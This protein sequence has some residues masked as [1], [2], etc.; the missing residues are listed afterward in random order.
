MRV[1]VCFWHFGPEACVAV[2]GGAS[3]RVCTDGRLLLRDRTAPLTVLDETTAC[4]EASEGVAELAEIALPATVLASA[5]PDS[6]AR[7][8]CGK[9]SKLAAPSLRLPLRTVVA[10]TTFVA[11][12][13][14]G[15]MVWVA[16]DN[17][18]GALGLGRGTQSA[19]SLTRLEAGHVSR[20]A[21]WASSDLEAEPEEA[22]RT[23]VALPRVASLACGSDHLALLDVHGWLWTCGSGLRGAT[24]HGT[25]EDVFVPRRLDSLGPLVPVRRVARPREGVGASA[26]PPPV[27]SRIDKD[28]TALGDPSKVA[29]G[30]AEATEAAPGPLHAASDIPSSGSRLPRH[31]TLLRGGTASVAC[32][33]AHTIV[34][35]ADGSLASWGCNSHGQLGLPRPERRLVASRAVDASRAG[36]IAR[37]LGGDA[38]GVELIPTVAAALPSVV[39]PEPVTRRQLP[40]SVAWEPAELAAGQG[41][42]S[43]VRAGSRH[44]VVELEGG[45]LLWFG[46]GCDARAPNGWQRRAAR[47]PALSA[48]GE[49]A[50][51]R[52]EAEA[53][54][55]LD[56]PARL[57][58]SIS[59]LLSPLGMRLRS[60]CR[61][62]CGSYVTAV[63]VLASIG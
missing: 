36:S 40:V 13:D 58:D 33:A 9:W 1:L 11:A 51:W 56:Q 17:C 61:V 37:S 31:H 55:V 35:M 28:A 10:G 59:A 60:V 14:E 18:S 50:V 12:L 57:D 48:A 63:E 52:F 2:L 16:G 30:K 26:L 21:P 54:M 45:G 6:L 8:A 27:R 7:L 41:S 32:G 46:Q 3:W 29:G 47:V 62:E 4:H 44:T 49:R 39:A 24:G 34:A 53:A 5:G 23:R 25:M 43:S 15:G 38:A 42:A 19:R 22:E 20:R